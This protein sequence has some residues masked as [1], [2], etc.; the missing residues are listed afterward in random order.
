[1]LCSEILTVR[2]ACLVRC[3]RLLEIQAGSR[4]TAGA[5]ATR[6]SSPLRSVS[7]EAFQESRDF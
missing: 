5:T 1:M 7:Q 2:A 3:R 4:G 6:V